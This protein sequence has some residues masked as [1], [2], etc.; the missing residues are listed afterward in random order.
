MGESSVETSGNG[1]VSRKY[2]IYRHVI[3]MKS[4]F[5]ATAF[6]AIKRH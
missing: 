5:K 2:R 4:L 3:L 6:H 1:F